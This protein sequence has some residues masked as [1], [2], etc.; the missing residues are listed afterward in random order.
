MSDLKGIMIY[1]TVEPKTFDK[2]EGGRMVTY[3][4][5]IHRDREGVET[6]RTEPKPLGSIGWSDGKPF[7][8]KDCFDLTEGRRNA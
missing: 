1:G 8:E 5:A 7:T 6:H 3:G 4:Y 2:F